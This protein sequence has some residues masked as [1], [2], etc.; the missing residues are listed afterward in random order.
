MK[1]TDISIKKPRSI[2]MV[3]LAVLLFGFISLTN[4]PVN[5]FPD[6]TF[7]MMLVLTTYPGAGPEEIEYMITDPLE[8]TLGTVNNVDKITSTTSENISLIN[9]QFDWG[10]DLDAASNDVRDN[11]GMLHPTCLKMQNS[12]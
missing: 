9:V 3:F 11:L 6:I 8:Q 2:S 5:L 12:H 4:L 1:I 7:P 10:T